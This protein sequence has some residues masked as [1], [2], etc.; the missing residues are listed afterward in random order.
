MRKR[1]PGLRSQRP[2]LI[3][4]SSLII[5]IVKWSPPQQHSA[6][7]SNVNL[8]M[9][10]TALFILGQQNPALLGCSTQQSAE[11]QSLLVSNSMP[12]SRT[13]ALCTLGQQSSLVIDSILHSHICNI[14]LISSATALYSSATSP[15]IFYRQHSQYHIL[16]IF[17][18]SS[19]GY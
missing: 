6:L 11:H 10:A 1:D 2:H 15:N 4:I 5:F 3:S 9:L 17:T 13:T 19:S 18:V 16:V 7:C 14:T 12:H 8:H